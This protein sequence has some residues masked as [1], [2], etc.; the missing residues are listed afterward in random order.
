MRI[1]DPRKEPEYEKV[2]PEKVV[3]VYGRKRG[4][5]TL[6]IVKPPS[7]FSGSPSVPLDRNADGPCAS[8]L[9]PPARSAT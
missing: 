6:C 9:R 8:P 3:V 2:E 7:S 1:G 4:L 5:D